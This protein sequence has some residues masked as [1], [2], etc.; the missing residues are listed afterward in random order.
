[1]KYLK[2]AFPIAFIL[3]SFSAC[4]DKDNQQEEAVF[5]KAPIMTN[6]ADN[7][8]IPHFTELKTRF[9]TLS[10]NWNAFLADQSLPNFDAV[11]A[12]YLLCNEEYQRVKM[13]D[14][15]P[16]MSYGMTMAFGIFPTDTSQIA[17]SISSGTYDLASSESEYSQG[18]DALDY[19]LFR[20]SAYSQLQSSSNA[21]MYVTDLINRMNSKAIAISQAWSG[22]YRS[23][24]IA[25]TGTSLTSP[26]ALLVNSFVK[27][28]ELTKNTKLGYPIGKQTLN[29]PRP[30]YFEAKWSKHNKVL[31]QTAIL[32]LSDVFHGTGT[33]GDGQGFDDYLTAVDQT[34]VSNSIHDKFQYLNVEISNW[35][36]NLQDRLVSNPTSLDSYYNYMSSMVVNLKTDMPSAFGVV[37]SYQ[38]NDGD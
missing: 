7:Y 31:L 21:R 3:I 9:N 20:A 1:M 4:K 28:F 14:F 30:L 32:A 11:K 22:S 15:G 23:E 10:T 2:I 8:M 37:I 18:L 27:D 13:F 5:D 17:A 12:S 26:F 34:T 29:N 25:G 35:N 33:A 19:L 38:D 16:A 36:D 24:F 6:L